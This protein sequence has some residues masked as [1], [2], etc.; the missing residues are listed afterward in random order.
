MRKIQTFILRLLTNTDETQTLRGAVRA[1]ADDEEQTFADE[2][3]LLALL[4]RMGHTTGGV[5]EA[6]R[7]E[8]EGQHSPESREG[9]GE[10]GEFSSAPLPLRPERR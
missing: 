4:R 1:V 2:Q 6:S 5:A 8:I 7:G 10:Q 9:A 3:A